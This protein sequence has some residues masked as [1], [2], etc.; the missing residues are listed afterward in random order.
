M[1]PPLAVAGLGLLPHEQSA[2]R[3]ALLA[4]EGQT[5]VPVRIGEVDGA[6]VVVVAAGALRDNRFNA[7]LRGRCV[8]VYRHEADPP[9]RA[10]DIVINA[11]V[12]VA[13]LGEALNAAF[14]RLGAAIRTEPSRPLA[15]DDVASVAP[16]QSGTLAHA[17]QRIFAQPHHHDAHVRVVGFGSLSVLTH[18][19]RYLADF[20]PS[21][22]R[23]AMRCR[24]YILSGNCDAAR[25]LRDSELRPLQEL[26]WLAALEGHD[27][28]QTRLPTRFRLLR[29]PDFS[30]LPHDHEHVTLAA[31]LSGQA[32]D[33]DSAC[34]LCDA[35]RSVVGAFL[36][37]CQA[38]GHLV[39]ADAAVPLPSG[40]LAPSER[41][42][43]F[44]ERWLGPFAS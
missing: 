4:L 32:L 15:A 42:L 29:W 20:E 23:V 5:H 17:L 34:R 18:R 9:A 44:M 27:S 13:Q 25:A 41:R 10:D 19:G 22:L 31:L 3:I 21:R 7:G 1:E 38:L 33:L 8:I 12:R 26:R 40:A 16:V 30:L 36:E 2:L 6:D 11:P 28:A 24:R 43:G 39:A 14:D 35:D 37:A